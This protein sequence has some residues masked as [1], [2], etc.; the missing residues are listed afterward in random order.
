MTNARC[1]KI[2]MPTQIRVKRVYDEASAS[3][4]CRVLV[5]RLW[6]RGVSKAKA[7]IDLWAKEMTPTDELRRWFHADLS[8]QT[9]FARRYRKE[10]HERT[11]E[12]KETLKGI[13]KKRITLVT[14]TKDLEHG[15]VGVLKK[16][17]ERI[18]G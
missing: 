15:H 8:R 2:A 5:D 11:S 18:V 17:L 10:L 9:E 13:T 12:I 4:G 14:A 16:F 7:R 3:D 1:G 6:P